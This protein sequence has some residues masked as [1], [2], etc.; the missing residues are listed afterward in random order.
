MALEARKGQNDSFGDRAANA[1]MGLGTMWTGLQ[2]HHPETESE[3]EERKF[4]NGKHMNIQDGSSSSD[5]SL[6]P[7][8]G[9]QN[10][11]HGGSE[12]Y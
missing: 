3:E 12:D 10:P 1:L 9:L 2:F 8:F 7:E 5:E 4:S 11:S 6:L